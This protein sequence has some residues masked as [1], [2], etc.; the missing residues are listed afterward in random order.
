ME[1]NSKKTYEVS[2]LA[3][4]ENGAA[5]MVGHLKSAGADIANEGRL[6]KMRLAYPIDRQG[7]AYFGCITCSLEAESVSK[8]HDAIRLDD[9]I[10]RILIL[11]PSL[12][13]E[14]VK[15]PSSYEGRRVDEVS[16]EVKS[17]K[18]DDSADGTLSNELLEEKLE[19]ILQQ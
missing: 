15:K 13:K 19:E 1:E 9:E 3:K 16:S 6:S 14:E 4:S 2:F 10:M 18:K 7:S 12:K 11:S 8:I 17:V 5:T